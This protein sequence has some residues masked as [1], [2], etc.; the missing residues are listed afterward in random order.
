MNKGLQ[1]ERGI[2]KGQ[3]TVLCGLFKGWQ[4]YLLTRNGFPRRRDIGIEIT[5]LIQGSRTEKFQ[6]EGPAWTITCVMFLAKKR[7][8]NPPGRPL[9]VDWGGELTG[10]GLKG[11]LCPVYIWILGQLWICY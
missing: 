6:A 9:A 4:G 1:L 5:E 8:L 3:S 10:H 7:N 2:V 11:P